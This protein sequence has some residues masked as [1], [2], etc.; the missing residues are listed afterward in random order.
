MRPGTNVTIQ[1]Q[2]PPASAPNNTGTWFVAGITTQGPTTP[3]LATSFAGW[4]SI[5]GA[6]GSNPIL[7]D[8]VET[9]FAQGG[10]QV[11]TARTV[12]PGAVNASIVLK[13][14][15]AANTLNIAAMGPGA[16]ANGYKIVV[17][18][19]QTTDFTITVEDANGNTLEASGTLTDVADAVAY[20][21][22]SQYITVTAVGITNPAAGTFAL[23]GGNDDIADIQTAQYQA[24]HE[25][26]TAEYGPGMRSVP[27]NS[28]TAVLTMLADLCENTIW[29]AIGDMP[30]TGTV[31]TL[32]STAATITALGAPARAIGLFAPW[33]DIAPAV[34]TTGN[35][36]VPPSAFYAGRAAASD[37]ATQNP[38]L[39]IAGL[40]GILSS[41][42]D[43]HYTFADT[44]RQ[45]LN[46][47]GINVIRQMAN[48]IRIYGNVTAVNRLTDPLYFMLSNVRLD[49]AIL[50]DSGAIQEDFM[51]SQIDGSGID[52]ANF[53]A[54]LVSMLTEW[55]SAPKNAIY[56]PF[57]VDISSDVNTP[58]TIAEGELLGTIAY[59]RSPGAEQVNLNIVRLSA[60]S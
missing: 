53:G 28:T 42:V 9:Y 7:S 23:A 35:R 15:A 4:Q 22:T 31:A 2:A 52:A 30:D 39:P 27:G 49:A 29:V 50:N 41:A 60:A 16:Y 21:A 3:Q 20:G 38:N 54:Q 26:F 59:S 37:G 48:D 58:T 44:D 40:N 18:T 57:T 24:A 1:S 8:A 43:V 12:G 14:A 17:T 55:Q 19:V 33:C 36:A 6:R 47:A 10:S 51:F 45:T 5:Y 46:T 34:G 56:G 13:D 11:W 25:Q 32:E